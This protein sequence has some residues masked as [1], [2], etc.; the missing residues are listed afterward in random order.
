MVL[1][2]NGHFD[3]GDVVLLA[4]LSRNLV[5]CLGVILVGGDL[6]AN[7]GLVQQVPARFL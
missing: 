4:Q 7:L 5:L 6:D 2:M 3:V 1:L